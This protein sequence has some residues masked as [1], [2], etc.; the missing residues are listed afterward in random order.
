[1]RKTTPVPFN[2]IRTSL[3]DRP[4]LPSTRTPEGEPNRCQ[5]CGKEFRLEPSRPPGDAPCPNCGSLMW[6]G[7]P[8]VRNTSRD[9]AKHDA[10]FYHA[11]QEIDNGD[12]DVAIAMLRFLAS[13]APHR[14]DYRRAL[15]RAQKERGGGSIRSRLLNM[16]NRLRLARA[17]KKND[18][19][20]I[21]AAAAD[22]LEHEPLDA[23]L[24]L[25]LGDAYR[26]RG[27]L[28]NAIFE[29]TCAYELLPQRSDIRETIEEL[30]K[31]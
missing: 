6:F 15:W 14:V 16:N 30:L 19:G 29:F 9:S 18:W 23:K 12:V 1:V 11:C 10:L 24:H 4:M 22:C 25:D 26:H 13:R 3:T 21:E 31:S 20:E 2:S 5:V 17:K 8:S 7:A 27:M 28:D